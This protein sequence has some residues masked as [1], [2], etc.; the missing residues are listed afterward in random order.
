MIKKCHST[1]AKFYIF[2][3]NSR[4]AIF[5]MPLII[6]GIL[7][8]DLPPDTRTLF[9]SYPHLRDVAAALIAQVPK[10]I[11]PVGLLYVHQR[12]YAITSPHDKHITILGTEDTTTCSMVVLRHSGS[13]VSCVAHFD[14]SGLEQGVVNIVRHVQD[15]SLNVPEGRLE[16]H[17]IGGFLDP[18]H[19]SEELAIQL[20]YAFHKQPLNIH[21]VTAC[22]CELNN[23]LR[24]NVNWPVIYGIGLNIKNGEIFPATFPDKG[25]DFPLRCARYFTGCYEM[26][27]IYDCHLGMLRIGPYNY[28]PLRGVDLWLSQ[29]DEF[30]LQH[31]STSPDVEPQAF[32]PQVRATL[33]Y[34]QQN[35]FPGITVFPDNRPHF[36]QKDESGNW[37]R[38]CY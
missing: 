23:T 14:G 38:V 19:Y 21:L 5:K 11:G 30:I 15:L 20:L 7:L 34:I 27:D 18:R 36:Y 35:P 10:V 31:L 1:S 25:P 33:K 2:Y 26:L 22:I 3:V 13:G 28:E 8:E 6:N 12:E 17:M 4:Y 32:V 16:L 9:E 37:I 24:G 29:N